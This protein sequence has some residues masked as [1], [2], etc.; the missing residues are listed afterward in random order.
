MVTVTTPSGATLT[1]EPLDLGLI[2]EEEPVQRVESGRALRAKVFERLSKEAA[3]VCNNDTVAAAT[4]GFP[5][6]AAAPDVGWVSD[7]IN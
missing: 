4:V 2:S 3:T 6:E 1:V 5:T 7:L